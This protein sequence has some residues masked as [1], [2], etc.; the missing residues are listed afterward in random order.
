MLTSCFLLCIVVFTWP[1]L[2]VYNHWGPVDE[3]KTLPAERLNELFG[4]MATYYKPPS[5]E[6]LS[7]TQA[8][9]L[10]VT[11]TMLPLSFVSRQGKG[12]TRWR[13]R[14]CE[15]CPILTA[16]QHGHLLQA[17]KQNGRTAHWL[18]MVPW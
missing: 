16:C 15:M 11:P 13:P 4:S 12:V 9:G 8:C 3:H 6:V 10:I 5:K 18:M 7:C 14:L 17:T 1:V 2:Q